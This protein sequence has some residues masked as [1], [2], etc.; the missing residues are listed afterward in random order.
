MTVGTRFAHLHTSTSGLSNAVL[1]KTTE[2][3]YCFRD[4]VESVC[5]VTHERDV[6]MDM[7]HCSKRCVQCRHATLCGG[8][9]HCW[10][11]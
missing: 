3:I 11:Q 7:W 2:F 8:F 9:K 4:G 5:L 1:D 6:I 10:N